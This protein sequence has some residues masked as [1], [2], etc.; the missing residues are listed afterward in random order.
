M[1]LQLGLTI[2]VIEDSSSTLIA[3]IAG[4][5]VAGI[6]MF[7]ADKISFPTI[8]STSVS[9]C[10]SGSTTSATIP[11]A[12]VYLLCCCLLYCGTR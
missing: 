5:F 8:N 1:E 11:F 3:D 2:N 12:S 7:V 10:S 4:A 6:W 9:S